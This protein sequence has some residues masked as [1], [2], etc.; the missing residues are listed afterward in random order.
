MALL[1]RSLIYLNCF[2]LHRPTAISELRT[3]AIKMPKNIIIVE[4][5]NPVPGI[6]QYILVYE[7]S[8]LQY[9]K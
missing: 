7:K 2:F 6:I 8:K 3:S 9:L 5:S 1:I 4:V